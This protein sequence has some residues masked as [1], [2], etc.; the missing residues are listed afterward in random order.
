[1]E[2]VLLITGLALAIFAVLLLIQKVNIIQL[3]TVAVSVYFW[4]YIIICGLLFWIDQFSIRR[5]MLGVCA[6]NFILCLFLVRRIKGI[7]IDFNIK[8]FI[9]PILII[10]LALPFM[11]EKYEFFGMGQ[12]EG[13]Y[14]TQAIYFIYNKNKVQ[15]DFEEYATLSDEDK[16]IYKEALENNLPGFYNYDTDLPFA[17]EEEELSEVSGVFHGIPTFPALLG[18]FG[19]LF[20]LS[21]MSDIQTIFYICMILFVYMT[22]DDMKIR[23]VL[24]YIL[25]ALLAFSPIVLWVSK[26]ALTEIGLACIM[27][28]FIYFVCKER[29]CYI[30][31]SVVPLIAFCF[32]H[33]T[34]YTMIPL[35]VFLYWLL[36]FFRGQKLYLWNAIIVTTAFQMG[37]LMTMKVAGTY[38]FVYNFLPIYNKLSFITMNNVIIFFGVMSV[39]FISISLILLKVKVD[40]PKLNRVFFFKGA[41][42]FFLILFCLI[43]IYFVIDKINTYQGVRNSIVHLSIV[44]YIIGL[45]IGVPILSFLIFMIKPSIALKNSHSLVVLPLF[46]YCVLIYCLVFR[47]DILYY[48]YYGRYLAPYLSILIL[49]AAIVLNRIQ[50]KYILSVGLMSIAILLP[51]DYFFVEYKDDTRIS[52]STLEDLQ[53]VIKPGNRIVFSYDYM[54]SLF[55]PLKAMLA[56]DVYPESKDIEIQLEQLSNDFEGDVYYID[57]NY[58]SSSLDVIYHNYSFASE[59]N[60]T[61]LYTILPLPR[62]SEQKKRRI[63][64]GK[65]QGDIIEYSLVGD[66]KNVYTVGIEHSEKDFAWVVN[67]NVYIKCNLQKE[68]YTLTF[69]MGDNIPLDLLKKKSYDVLLFIN[70][71]EFGK[72]TIDSSNNG[73]EISVKLPEEYINKGENMLYLK[74]EMWSPSE[75]GSADTRDLG[76]SLQ[77]IIF[78]KN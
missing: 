70:D 35:F 13:V 41:M 3:I 28:G 67:K 45:G 16:K 69:I 34:I 5:G 31:L 47:Q 72:I 30:L 11:A 61:D 68:D 27:A 1:M 71:L 66:E 64:C 38:S 52:W 32:F 37:I 25:T 6:L 65:Y 14:Q 51:F 42:R 74:S 21:H 40:T 55:L 53:R 24:K 39:C 58:W 57:D 20:G 54:M 73:N 26:S 9:I 29:K 18:M 76:M 23:K 19:R 43:Q 78:S 7:V 12:D 50:T 48:Y 62:S 33:L 15:Q 36:N 2:A 60:G 10:I 22:M 17:S 63:V 44:G 4:Q 75:Y 46:Y 8:T 49:L 59:D 56:A 77:K